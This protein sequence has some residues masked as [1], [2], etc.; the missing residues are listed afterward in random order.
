MAQSKLNRKNLPLILALILVLVFAL[1]AIIMIVQ[2]SNPPN[3][4]SIPETPS[5]QS[6]RG[7]VDALLAMAQPENAETVISKYSCNACHREGQGVIAPLFDGL[8]ARAADRRPP[9][10][11]DAYIYEAIVFPGAF[12][13]EG[14]NDLMPPD[15]GTRM[16][17]QEL[18]DVLA[19]LLTPDAH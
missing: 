3:V 6:Y 16:T 10:P 15:F 19:Y 17:D 2:F 5:A 1:F 12:V 14:Y 8:A 11:A 13:V 4:G 9:M 7:R 18:A